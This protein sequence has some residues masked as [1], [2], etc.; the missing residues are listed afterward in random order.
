MD[1]KPD[2]LIAHVA[3]EDRYFLALLGGFIVSMLLLFGDNCGLF[4]KDVLTPSL[5]VYTIGTGLIGQIQMMAGNRESLRRAAAG[6]QFEGSPRQ[7][8]VAACTAHV[9]W[10]VALIGWLVSAYTRASAL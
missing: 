8:F 1:Q 6:Q 3:R 2:S 10:F 5:V 7:V 4:V 9:L